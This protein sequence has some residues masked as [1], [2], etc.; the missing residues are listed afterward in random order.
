[1]LRIGESIDRPV[2]DHGLTIA[3]LNWAK[4]RKRGFRR[5]VGCYD[6]DTRTNRIIRF[7]LPDAPEMLILKFVDLDDPAP[8]PHCERSELRMPRRSDVER[9]LAFDRPGERLLIHC[10]AGISRSSAIAVALIAAR[11]GPG[12]EDDAVDAVLAIR[13]QAVPNLAVIRHA[14]AILERSGRLTAAVL[15]RETPEWAARR[16]ANRQAYLYYYGAS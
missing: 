13:P 3:P 7:H 12:H 6:P 11:L 4:R 5:I 15:A 1:M 10:H 9:A 16:A 8:A 14:D 2:T